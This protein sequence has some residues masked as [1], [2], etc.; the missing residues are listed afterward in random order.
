[1]EQRLT[2]VTQ[3]S[4]RFF[5][6]FGRLLIWRVYMGRWKFRTWKF[7]TWKCYIFSGGASAVKELGHFDVRKSS[8]QVTRSQGR[9]QD[10]PSKKFATFVVVALKTQAAN[11]VD[12]FI[13]TVKIYGNIYIF[14]LHCY[15]SKTI[16]RAEPGRW[17]FQP[18]HLTWRAL[19]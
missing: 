16:G 19:V 13:F 14:C 1:M 17:I 10:F 12:C 7:R 8:S 18:G 4:N 15:R 9:S 3:W 6:F 5:D 11:A 2:F